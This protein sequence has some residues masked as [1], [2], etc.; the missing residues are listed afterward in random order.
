MRIARTRSHAALAAATVGSLL[1]A[2]AATA[3]A[4]AAAVGT[5]SQPAPITINDDSAS[6][7]YGTT[8]TVSG[9]T[10]PVTD[11]NLTLAGFS[12]EYPDDVIVMLVGPRGQKAVVMADVGGSGTVTD[13]NLTLD[14]EA[15]AA[16]PDET[17][18]VSG[19]FR[20]ADYDTATAFPAP[21][22]S[23]G[24]GSALS[25]FDGTDPNGTWQLFVADDAGSDVGSI[26]RGWSLQISTPDVPTAPVFTAPANPSTDNDGS[27]AFVGTA[28]ANSTVNVY[29]GTT[30]VATAAAAATGGWG[31]S[32][33]GLADGT[34]TFTAVAVDSYGNSSASSTPLT[35]TVDTV[36]PRVASTRPAK[37]ADR[38]RPGANVKARF[39]EAVRS[40]TITKKTVK[41][42]EAG[43]KKAVRA[44]VTYNAATR[45]A[46]VNPRQ[47]L[48]SGTT[49]KVIVGTGVKDVAGNALDQKSRTGD[50]P[51][52]WRF[53]TR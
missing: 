36:A 50:Q 25:V 45:T 18:L 46:K 33:Q 13:L 15:A 19:S 32:V 43:Q 17:D 31:T 7:P 30:H 42:V 11:L 3:P 35:V 40:A 41:V 16:L 23:T 22:D 34:H 27:V 24:A 39:G 8:I 2:A 37:G 5:Y 47:H 49:Y 12:H 1:A 48:V 9:S 28:P 53:T 6:T 38:V 14:D 20:P 44:T 4:A 21:A 52:V 29:D 51:M 26:S 10:R